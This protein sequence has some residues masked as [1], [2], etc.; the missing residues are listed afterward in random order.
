MQVAF[1]DHRYLFV[2]PKYKGKNIA[3]SDIGKPG[4]VNFGG[5]K[6][7]PLPEGSENEQQWP[8]PISD[9]LDAGDYKLTVSEDHETCA[10]NLQGPPELITGLQFSRQISIRADSPEISFRAVMKNASA[11]SIRWSIQSVS[12]YDTADRRDPAK[13]NHEFWA[14]APTNPHSAYV[15]DYWVR[16]G[17]ADDPSFEVNSGKFRLHWLPLENELWLD[18]D[19]GWI[20][21]VDDT[22]QFGMIERFRYEAAAEYPGKATVIFYKNGAALQ[23]DA[24]GTPIMRSRPGEPA[25]Y[26]MEAEINS[27]MIGLQPGSSYAM[28]TEWFPVRASKKLETVTWAGVAWTPPSASFSN[29]TVRIVGKFGVFFPGKLVARIFDGQGVMISEVELRAVDPRQVV[30][31]DQT[32]VASANAQRVSIH[33]RDEQGQDRGSLGETKISRTET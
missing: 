2:N 11:H 25:P 5:D 28:D 22:D 14:I 21:V 7:W 17:L 33:L 9:A 19:A 32:T 23:L 1:D 30:E 13:Y 8:G 24:D 15:G 12:Q 10:A 6:L 3:P 4:W 18:S 26:Y 31:L 16:A 29:G 20:A 27:P